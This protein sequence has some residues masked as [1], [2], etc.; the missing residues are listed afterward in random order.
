SYENPV[1][2]ATSRDAIGDVHSLS[3]QLAELDAPKPTSLL[4]SLCGWAHSPAERE[5]W[6]QISRM[7][8]EVDDVCENESF[9][10]HRRCIVEHTLNILLFP[11]L[12]SERFFGHMNAAQPYA[13]TSEAQRNSSTRSLHLSISGLSGPS[14]PTLTVPGIGLP[15]PSPLHL[16]LHVFTRLSFNEQGRIIHHRD[17]WDLKDLV[18]LIPGGMLSQWVASRLAARVLSAMSRLI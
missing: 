15:F 18:G 13:L 6:F 9:D 14:L 1:I 17:V 2:T 12:H 10:G 16:K 7:W 3:Q 8:T 4:R 5:S 11:G